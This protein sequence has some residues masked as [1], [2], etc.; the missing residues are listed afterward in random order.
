MNAQQPYGA[1]TP[2]PAPVL[3]PFTQTERTERPLR[4]SQETV[5]EQREIPTDLPPQ[6]PQGVTLS[7]EL[8][9]LIGR[10]QHM[11]SETLLLLGLLWLLYREHA[12]KKLLLALAYIII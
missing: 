2:P 6:K 3:Q 11:D 8:M 7:P 4:R 5:P 10:I 9:Q 12:D 1:R